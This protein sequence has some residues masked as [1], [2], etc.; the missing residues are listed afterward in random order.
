MQKLL[1]GCGPSPCLL[2]HPV[3]PHLGA[4]A[5]Q[6]H[7]EDRKK[8]EPLSWARQCRDMSEAEAELLLWVQLLGLP[9]LHS[10]SQS[11]LSKQSRA[12]RDR[13]CQAPEKGVGPLCAE[14]ER[15]V[16]IIDLRSFHEPWLWGRREGRGQQEP[17]QAQ[18]EGGNL[19][20]WFPYHKLLIGSRGK[21]TRW[22]CPKE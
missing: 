9:L 15:K 22:T 6:A 14:E 3:L 4:K 11:A 7:L 8:R 10:T 20:K 19:P 16:R 18:G 21:Q 1:A 5:A 17:G 13:R 2:Q 12:L